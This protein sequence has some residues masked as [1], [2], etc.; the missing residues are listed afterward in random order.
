M[1]SM[2]I[3]ILCDF[4]FFYKYTFFGFMFVAKLFITLE[5]YK[6]NVS[7]VNERIN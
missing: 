6:D 1:L 7:N 3:P 4:L 2:I 5:I